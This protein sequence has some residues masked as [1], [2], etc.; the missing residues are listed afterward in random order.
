M[1]RRKVGNKVAHTHTHTNR[2]TDRQTDRQSDTCVGFEGLVGLF[3]D[4]DVD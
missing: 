2:Q 4:E 3:L 1:R